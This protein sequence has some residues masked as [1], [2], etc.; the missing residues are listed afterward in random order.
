M[1]NEKRPARKA[2]K[3]VAKR[4]K[5]ATHKTPAAPEPAAEV[6]AATPAAVPTATT[7]ATS[8]E[9]EAS[10]EGAIVAEQINSK[11]LGTLTV[12]YAARDVNIRMDGGHALDL[13]AMFARGDIPR[14]IDKIRSDTVATRG[15]TV[16]DT[17]T[18]LG[19]TWT[20]TDLAG[21]ART[22]IDP[23]EAVA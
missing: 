23:G 6:D 11:V 14:E 22:T 20:P 9:L 10:V 21:I 12:H 5:Q 17:T 19:M 15:F 16:I 18:P 8:S 4:V 7:T 2:T 1:P 3:A 13:L